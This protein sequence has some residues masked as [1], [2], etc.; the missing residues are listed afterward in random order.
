MSHYLKIFF[1]IIF[2]DVHDV[3][4]FKDTIKKKKS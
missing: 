1:F 2:Y 4:S 3:V